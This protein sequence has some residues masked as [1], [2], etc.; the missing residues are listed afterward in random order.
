MDNLA[1]RYA[2][3]ARA[4]APTIVPVTGSIVQNA[5]IQLHLRMGETRKGKKREDMGEKRGRSYSERVSEIGE[6]VYIYLGVEKY[7]VEIG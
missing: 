5:N 7:Q 2:L 4:V 1:L 3:A 6:R